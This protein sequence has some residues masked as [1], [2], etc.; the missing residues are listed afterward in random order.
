MN[1][2]S[3][4]KLSLLT[5][6]TLSGLA[7][8]M[9][10]P[11]AALAEE[12]AP[13]VAS[14]GQ[15]F[16]FVAT[17]LDKDDHVLAGKEV[18]VSDVTDGVAKVVASAKTGA[19]G[20]A[21]FSNLP[22]SR[23]LSV[24]VDGVVKGYTVRTDV[25]GSTQTGSFKADGVGTAAPSY[26]KQSI[27]LTI[28]DQEGEAY[29][30]QSVSLKTKEGK[31]VGKGISDVSGKVVFA[32]KLVDG[33]FYDVFVNGVQKDPILPGQSRSLLIERPASAIPS[34]APKEA[35]ATP[36][37]G[38]FSF[39]ATVLEK[40]QRVIP[41]KEVRLYDITDGK[42]VELAV[43]K[44]DDKGQARFDNLPLSR[45]I[46]VNVDGKPQGYTVRTDQDK[47]QKAAAFYVEGKGT[48]KVTFSAGKAVIKV[49]NEESEALAGQ[50]VVLKNKL[51]LEVAKGLTDKT[52]HVTFENSLLDGTIYTA[53]VNG[54]EMTKLVTTGSSTTFFLAGDQIKKEEPKAKQD[55]TD[56]AYKEDKPSKES[57]S[58]ETSSMAADKKVSTTTVTSPKA[59]TGKGKAAKALPHTGERSTVF[60]S[61]IGLILSTTLILFGLGKKMKKD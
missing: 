50:E 59:V 40:D 4:R 3:Y 9:A 27:I 24:S 55:K 41:G 7:V 38:S 52:G 43:Q 17:I 57:K 12:A 51:G 20:Q 56:S 60:L 35:D 14:V 8:S 34:P 22:L 53:V 10:G 54:V 42:S 45:N 47:S 37:K 33:T 32:D 6:A 18:V 48:Q 26:S 11:N 29:S 25:A 15:G 30:G 19:N 39:T 49:V 31:E 13:R 61:F 36:V 1:H 16:N 46:S 5:V 23:S 21:T 2:V 44:T 58:A 28:R